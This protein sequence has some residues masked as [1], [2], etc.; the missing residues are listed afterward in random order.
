VIAIG[1]DLH[2]EGI[3]PES[4]QAVDIGMSR[5]NCSLVGERYDAGRNSVVHAQF[6][7]AYS[8][9]RALTQGRVGLADYEMPAIAEPAIAELAQRVRVAPDPAIDPKAMEP[10]MVSVGLRD[11]STL[12]RET[13]TLKG[14]PDD[15]MS[16]REILDKLRDALA[17][18][19]D[20]SA[21]ASGQLGETVLALAGAPDAAAAI[22]EAFRAAER[23]GR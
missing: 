9:A 18:G 4:V 10:T 2:R 15:P 22:C 13:R 7:A 19:L 6:S 21:E 5:V 11:G 16:R 23:S 8:F 20:A 12:R 14:A 17:F 1:I 3:R